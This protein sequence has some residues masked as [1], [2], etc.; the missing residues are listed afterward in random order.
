VDD[1]RNWISDCASTKKWKL[2]NFVKKLRSDENEKMNK[3]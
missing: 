1:E 3:S 2:E